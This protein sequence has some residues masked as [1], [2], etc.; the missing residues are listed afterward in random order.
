MNS[1]LPRPTL[2]TVL[3]IGCVKSLYK[4][5]SHQIT[6]LSNIRMGNKGENQISY[7]LPP[8]MLGTRTARTL[9]TAIIMSS[10]FPSINSGSDRHKFPLVQRAFSIDWVSNITDDGDPKMFSQEHFCFSASNLFLLVLGTFLCPSQYTL[11]LHP[12]LLFG[13]IE[14]LLRVSIQPSL[15]FPFNCVGGDLLS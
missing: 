2:K 12:Q 13:K 4:S 15:L 1:M 10:I 9:A 14:F 7:I 5:T 11:F 8:T 6:S 3:A